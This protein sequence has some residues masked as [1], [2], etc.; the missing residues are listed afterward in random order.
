MW[1][2]PLPSL[3]AFAGFVFIIFKRPNAQ[4]EI[5]YAA[6]LIVA[7]LA[8]YLL[9]ARAR[10]EFPFGHATVAAVVEE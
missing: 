6:V 2:Y 7:G 8:V 3:L 5:K 1:L 9:R 10:G 4:K